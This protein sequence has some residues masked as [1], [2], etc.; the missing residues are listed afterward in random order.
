MDTS[1]TS[2]T[3]EA[4]VNV[5][6]PTLYTA[7][8][9][10]VN[11]H[12]LANSSLLGEATVENLH[13]TKG[14]NSD[15]LVTAK[16]DPSM[17][18]KQARQ[19]GRE[20]I[21]QYLSGFNTSVTIKTHQNSI[22]GQPTLCDALSRFNFTFAAPKMELPGDG[23]DVGESAHFIRDATFHFFTSTATVTLVSPLQHNTIY[24]DY[25]NA[26]AFYN[27]TEP[28]GK[29]L[30]SLPFSAPPGESQTPRLP[31]QWSVGSVGYDKLRNAIGGNLRLDAYADV[32]VRLGNWIESIWY[33]GNGIGANIQI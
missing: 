33:M 5:T 21:S 30:H 3:I 14:V 12:V 18:D 23:T 20:L 31:V 22:P 11:I 25:I 29:I 15:I 13:I 10:F 9:P 16:W 6:N 28:V 19:V 7:H 1:P 27:H 24:I 2:V 17:G 26:T 8:I 4:V 32:N